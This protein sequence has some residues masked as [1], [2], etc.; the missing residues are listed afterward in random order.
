MIMD[1]TIDYIEV[2][3][4]DG[5]IET[6]GLLTHFGIVSK[7]I[8][9][10]TDSTNTNELFDLNFYTLTRIQIGKSST[11][12]DTIEQ[13]I[14][15]NGK[16]D[17]EAAKMVLINN[18]K[19]LEMEGRTT[20]SGFLTK[21]TFRNVPEK[22]AKAKEGITA[23]SIVRDQKASSLG[24][25]ADS[26]TQNTTTG[27]NIVYNGYDNSYSKRNV[28]TVSFIPRTSK[29]PSKAFLKSMKAKVAEVT[30]KTFKAKFP[31]LG[32]GLN[33]PL[34]TQ[35]DVDEALYDLCGGL[36]EGGGGYNQYDY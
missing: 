13:Y 28:K 26:N 22:Y 6:A 36:G 24:G 5:G 2:G 7:R 9:L 19:I 15:K 20:V 35:D 10:I 3:I 18:L 29:L 23:S 27:N 31:E 21:D 34:V 14:F 4:F 8:R 30:A 32:K 12:Y 25:K 17:Q 16:D 1:E 33:V 11:N